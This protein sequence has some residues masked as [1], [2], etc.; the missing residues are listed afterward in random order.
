MP[1]QLMLLLLQRRR[2][3]AIVQDILLHQLLLLRPLL[4]PLAQVVG[5]ALALELRLLGLE[6]WRGCGVQ[7]DVPIFEVLFFGA[8]LV[9][10]C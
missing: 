10:L 6:G 3:I 7:E 9:S 1:F 5:D 2:R 8:V 4:Q